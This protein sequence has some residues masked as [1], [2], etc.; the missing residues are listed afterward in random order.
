[1]HAVAIGARD[2]KEH[3][4]SIRGTDVVEKATVSAT[5]RRVADEQGRFGGRGG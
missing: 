1:V 5:I 3:L 2:A 4:F